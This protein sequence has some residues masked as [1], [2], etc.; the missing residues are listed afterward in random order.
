M[1]MAEIRES[2]RRSLMNL[3][4]I[5]TILHP[6]PSMKHPTLGS[7]LAATATNH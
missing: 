2:H 1:I 4:A 7:D 5:A 6:W 3:A